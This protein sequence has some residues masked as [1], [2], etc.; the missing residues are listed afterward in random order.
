MNHILQHIFKN[1]LSRSQK[2]EAV[3]DKPSKK[4]DINEREN[5]I[6]FKINERYSLRFFTPETMKLLGS[7]KSKINKNENGKMCIIYKLMKW[8]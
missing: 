6:T 3:T 1:I 7:I 5:R 8:Y 4:N 2:T